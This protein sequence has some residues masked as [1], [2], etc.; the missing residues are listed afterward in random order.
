MYIN[1][2]CNVF[3]SSRIHAF[4]M[5][6]NNKINGFKPILK[7][8]QLASNISKECT[9]NVDKSAE[10]S[11][12]SVFRNTTR[13]LHLFKKQC[14]NEENIENSPNRVNEDG[15]S[16]INEDGPNKTNENDMTNVQRDS[17]INSY[18]NKMYAASYFAY[19]NDD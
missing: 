2:I 10:K 13:I 7:P 3:V 6:R 9:E 16:R 1:N 19:G 18:S 8:R 4:I 14:E 17:S 5:Y 12:Y 11:E 15:P